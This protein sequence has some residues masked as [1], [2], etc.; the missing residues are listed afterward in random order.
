MSP[1]AARAPPCE[2]ET[3]GSD[4]PRAPPTGH[5]LQEMRLQPPEVL[6][7]RQTPGPGSFRVLPNRLR[8][9]YGFVILFVCTFGMVFTGP[10]QT[11]SV[12]ATVTYVIRDLHFSRTLVSGLF[13]LAT[14]CSAAVLPGIGWLIDHAGSRLVFPLMVAC[15][16]LSCAFYAAVASSPR[17]LLFVSFLCLRV[18]GQGGLFLVS[19]NMLNRWFVKKRARMVGILSVVVAFCLT[20]VFSS[21]VKMYVEKHG[22]RFCYLHLALIELGVLFPLAAVLSANSPEEYGLLPDNEGEIPN[23]RTSSQQP[24]VQPIGLAAETTDAHEPTG[25]E[26]DGAEDSSSPPPSPPGSRAR[27]VPAWGLGGKS[28]K[29]TKVQLEV[30]LAERIGGAGPEFSSADGEDGGARDA[31]ENAKHAFVGGGVVLD[32]TFTLSEAVRT[33][34]FWFFVHGVCVQNVL[35]TA[36]FFHLDNILAHLPVAPGAEQGQL[37]LYVYLSAATS[38]CVCSITC[39]YMA[40]KIRYERMTQKRG[41]CRGTAVC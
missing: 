5:I 22:V 1:T 39:G 32:R 35:I 4:R 8:P 33:A 25:G 21:V 41:P 31:V 20:G 29:Y 12:G 10:A 27:R 14:M 3:G 34:E 7:P 16:G 26:D 9:V 23:Q 28:P 15:L 2:G 17:L 24:Q 38:A 19:T 40:E 6:E 11:A 30:E 36:M 13:L 37:L 18:S